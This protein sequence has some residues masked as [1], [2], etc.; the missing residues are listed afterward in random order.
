M[1]KL[2]LVKTQ[3]FGSQKKM[4]A[5]LGIS[6]GKMS[7]IFSGVQ[8]MPQAAI[9]RLA[10]NYRI[11]LHWLFSPEENYKIE[12]ITDYVARNEVDVL[13]EKLYI[14]NEKLAQYMSV[15]NARLKNI[16]PLSE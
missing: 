9:E 5:G 8:D 14:A 1:K 10:N 13:K 6:P 11:N 12:Y 16:D 15:E 7:Y 3:I 4:A 2:D